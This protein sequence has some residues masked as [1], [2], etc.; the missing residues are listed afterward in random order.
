MEALATKYRPKKFE[1]VVAQTYVRDILLNQLEMKEFKNGYLFTGSAGTGKTSSARIFA[2]EVNK[3]KG[4]PI[5]IDAA[6]NNSVANIRSVIDDSKFRSMDSEFKFYIIDECVTG[7]T[8]ILTDR[9][10]IRIDSLKETD[11][12][13][14]YEEDGSITFVSDWK[15]VHMQYKGD[16]YSVSFR[17]GRKKCLMS[18]NHVQPLR[19]RKTGVLK[20]FYIKDCNFHQGNE[21]VVAGKGVGNNTPLTA[22]ERIM[23]AAQAD[24]YA[25]KN[26]LWEFHLARPEKIERLKMLLHEADIDYRFYENEKSIDIRFYLDIPKSKKLSDMFDIEMGYER[27][28]DFISE[29]LLWDG[30]TKS[31]YPGYY[32]STNKSNVDF[33]SAILA[34]AGYSANQDVDIYENEN[35]K[36]VHHVNWFE[37]DWRPSTAISKEKTY[38]EGDIYCVKVPSQKIILRAEGFTFVSGNCHMLSTGA[39]NALLKTLEEPPAGTIFIL[40]TTDPQ[41]I[42]ATILSRVQRFDF[43]RIDVDNI[44]TRL[45]YIIESENN[46]GCEYTYTEEGLEFIA[47]LANGGMRDAIS[48]LEKV[49]DYSNDVTVENVGNALGAPDY[50][51]FLN[52]LRAIASNESADSLEII[53]SIYMSGRDLKLA[54]RNFT[55]F[56]VDICR[57]ILTDTLD[58]T[59]IPLHLETAVQEAVTQL[60]YPLVLWMLEELNELNSVIKWEPNPKPIVDLQILLMTKDDLEDE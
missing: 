5:E 19:S 1:D 47:K 6:S 4:T 54:M 56:V 24:G 45:V 29:I 21:V 14:Q 37:Q 17:N 26:D 40:C 43:S 3:G 39:W 58:N 30:S 11:K 60:D 49:L 20:E 57:Y 7:D 15:P 31:G 34:L 41:K 36:N 9:G 16:M 55:D 32:S 50:E 51:T 33:V 8:E 27:A 18:P 35:H 59:Q 28:K 48:R 44:V 2:N 13:A 25:G 52:L 53:D 38:Y 12:V 10:Y 42:P 46:E 23:I 22:K